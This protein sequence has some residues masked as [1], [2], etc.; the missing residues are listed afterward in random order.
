[1]CRLANKGWAQVG[2]MLDFPVVVW[3]VNWSAEVNLEDLA[4]GKLPSIQV[5]T[6]VKKKPFYQVSYKD[7]RASVDASFVLV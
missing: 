7:Q 3:Q 6:Q 4:R 2:E 5:P 1:M